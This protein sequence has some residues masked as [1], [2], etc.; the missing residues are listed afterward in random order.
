MQKETKEKTA[1]TAYEYGAVSS[2]FRLLADNKL[3]AYAAMI[4]HFGDSAG[5]LV[6]Y[7][8]ETKVPE[9][10]IFING[11]DVAERVDKVFGGPGEF[12]NYIKMNKPEIEKCYNT[13]KRL[14]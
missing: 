1:L 7:A 13:I 10:S 6:L 11:S 4:I 9:W 12:L 8:P 5:M 3:T 2:R 14:V